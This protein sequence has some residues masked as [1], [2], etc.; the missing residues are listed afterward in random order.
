M[1]LLGRLRLFTAHQYF[2]SPLLARYK[3]ELAAFYPQIM[4]VISGH[5]HYDWS[6][7]FAVDALHELPMI[8]VRLLVPS[9]VTIPPLRFI[10]I[11]QR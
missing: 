8:S 2:Q 10:I 1:Y 3:Q 11:C 5:L 7:F 4:G 6:Q 9:L